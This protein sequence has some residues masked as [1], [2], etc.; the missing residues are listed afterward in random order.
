VLTE[1]DFYLA[2]PLQKGQLSCRE[3]IGGDVLVTAVGKD[4]PITIHA[5]DNPYS[6]PGFLHQIISERGIDRPD[7]SSPPASLRVMAER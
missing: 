1:D 5:F 7:A 3:L 6:R 2:I 4:E